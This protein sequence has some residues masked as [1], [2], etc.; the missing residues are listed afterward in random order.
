MPYS[1]VDL[2]S[3][4]GAVTQL[5]AGGFVGVGG[6]HATR[7]V[8]GNLDLEIARE[9]ASAP[10]PTGPRRGTAASR[11]ASLLGRPQHLPMAR[12]KRSQWLV[13]VNCFRPAGVRR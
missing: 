8:L 2:L 11:I 3:D 13:S 1:S 4:A 5:A 12:T 7:H 10:D 9:L 6:R